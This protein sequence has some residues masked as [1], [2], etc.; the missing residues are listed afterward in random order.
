MEQIFFPRNEP[1]AHTDLYLDA[2]RDTLL[3][4]I[5]S[6]EKRE[7]QTAPA[8]C[9]GPWVAKQRPG[10]CHAARQHQLRLDETL[11]YWILSVYGHS[12][13]NISLGHSVRLLRRG[14]I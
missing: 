5:N 7:N 14:I 13:E 2:T 9:F 8:M 10:L 1:E 3:A 12:Y 4:L 6:N 11:T